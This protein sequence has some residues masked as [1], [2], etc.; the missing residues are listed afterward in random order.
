MPRYSS[1]RRSRWAK[2]RTQLPTRRWARFAWP[3]LPIAVRV[4]A[5]GV[6]ALARDAAREFEH[7]AQEAGRHRRDRVDAQ[8]RRVGR[9]HHLEGDA[10]EAL[11]VAAAEEQPDD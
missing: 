3:T 10:D 2:R 8:G 11:L 1:D 5:A 4:A 9:A 6:V 7:L